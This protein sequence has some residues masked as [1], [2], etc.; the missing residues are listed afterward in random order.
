MDEK[1]Q[2]AFKEAAKEAE[3][4]GAFLTLSNPKKYHVY[5]EYSIV[6]G[7]KLKKA[8]D[9]VL[10]HIKKTP[11]KQPEHSQ[12]NCDSTWQTYVIFEF[13]SQEE[14]LTWMGKAAYLWMNVQFNEKYFTASTQS[15]THI[16][17]VSS[18]WIESASEEEK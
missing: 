2:R 10:E 13:V 9:N 15:S 16:N 11:I 12:K 3:R 14:L 6:K 7:H 8:W 5:F 18:I 4:V 1:L 17:L